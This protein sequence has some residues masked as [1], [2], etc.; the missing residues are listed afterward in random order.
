MCDHRMCNYW[1]CSR[2]KITCSSCCLLKNSLIL[3]L[4]MSFKL[5]K[6]AKVLLLLYKVIK[7]ANHYP[8]LSVLSWKE[9]TIPVEQR[10][11]NQCVA[12]AEVHT[13]SAFLWCLLISPMSAVY[14]CV[15]AIVQCMCV[16]ALC[17]ICCFV[18][19]STMGI[20]K[21][22]FI[23][24]VFI[25]TSFVLY[26]RDWR[27]LKENTGLSVL[28]ITNFY[29]SHNQSFQTSMIAQIFCI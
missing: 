10:I 22:M 2:G 26:V 14:L 21:D 3:K 6:S 25:I 13:P 20:D 4:K 24:L 19:R 29:Q 7:S 12:L 27:G 8:S 16:I 18:F 9:T 17:L 1:K 28:F 23:S 5:S 11:N 15:A